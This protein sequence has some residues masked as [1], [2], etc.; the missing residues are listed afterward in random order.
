MNALVLLAVAATTIVVGAKPV[1]DITIFASKDAAETCKTERCTLLTPAALQ[2]VYK[3]GVEEGRRQ[4][5]TRT[6]SNRCL[7]GIL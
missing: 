3:A 6:D 5:L 2:A 1:E 7:R 4:F